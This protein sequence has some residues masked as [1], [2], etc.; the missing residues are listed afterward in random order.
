MKAK[1]A[2]IGTVLLIAMLVTTGTSA[3][4]QNLIVNGGFELPLV[5]SS[6]LWDIFPSGTPG[7]AWLVEWAGNY[8]GAPT[9][10]NIELQTRIPLWTPY[11]GD[12]YA[13]LDSDYHHP[14]G[15]PEVDQSSIRI[16]Q[17]IPTCPGGIFELSYAWS[18]RPGNPDNK[19]EVYWGGTLIARYDESGVGHTSTGWTLA[20][21]KLTA[22]GATTRLEFVEVGVPD[23]Q[24]MFV[25]AVKVKKIACRVNVDIEV[26]LN[27]CCPENQAKSL[28]CQ[29][30]CKPYIEVTILGSSTFDVSQ[31]DPATLDLGNMSVLF[32]QAGSQC[33][34]ADVTGPSSQPDGFADLTCRFD[35]TI[36]LTGQLQDG[37]P[38]QGHDDICCGSVPPCGTTG[39]CTRT[40][41]YWKTHSKYGPAPYD[42]VW[43]S[44]DDG[45]AQLFDTGLSFYQVL[46]TSP[47]KGNAFFIL[48]HQYIA[49]E[50]NKIG[51][52]SMPSE[53]LDAWT[54][55]GNLLDTYDSGLDIP[56][57]S[58]DRETAIQLA[59]LLDSYNNGE[60]GPGHCSE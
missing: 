15:T 5:Q 34:I 1:I 57:S 24:G 6:L 19:M 26:K 11:E 2:A 31:V 40:L 41:G 7:L 45:D 12:Q 48:A 8:P 27:P 55:A 51:G 47:D 14:G 17:D 49:A 36:T 39:G 38:I 29:V 18:P 4:D 9:P 56:K 28:G 13:E 20:T 53:V 60:I 52:A 54:Q 22:P 33:S 32:D 58:S 37:T 59:D 23:N 42:N 21:H 44:R 50:M 25:D 35:N 46:T 16:S 3:Q 10:A 43:N 30:E